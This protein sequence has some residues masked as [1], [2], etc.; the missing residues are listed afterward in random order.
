MVLDYRLRRTSSIAGK[1]RKKVVV[2]DEILV[3]EV[4]SGRAIDGAW[5]SRPMA[6]AALGVSPNVLD[7]RFRELARDESGKPG[8]APCERGTGH[9][10]EVYVRALVEAWVNFRI[11][12]ALGPLREQLRAARAAPGVPDDAALW[13]SGDGSPALERYRAARADLAELDLEERRGDLVDRREFQALLLRTA[14]ILRGLGESLQRQYGPDAQGLLDEAID[15]VEREVQRHFAQYE[16]NGES[17][18]HSTPGAGPGL[19]KENGPK[20]E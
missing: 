14:H 13:D 12:R 11:E 15:D 10:L 3:S 5:L 2:T 9:T 19:I 20:L 16:G 17:R 1:S 7:K 8:A 4:A 6:A 18:D